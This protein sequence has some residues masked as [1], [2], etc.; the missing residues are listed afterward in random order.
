MY[1]SEDCF[2]LFLVM[3]STGMMLVVIRL[4]AT[5]VCPSKPPICCCSTHVFGFCMGLF[6]FRLV[7]V[8]LVVGF[9]YFASAIVDDF[10]PYVVCAG[11][12]FKVDGVFDAL[13]CFS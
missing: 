13:D 7:V 5:V 4:A 10:C 1:M 2:C 11:F 3:F 6:R 8:S 9:E 12:L